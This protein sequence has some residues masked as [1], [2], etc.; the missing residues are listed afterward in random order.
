LADLFSYE[1][2]HNLANG[3]NNS[4]GS[5]DNLST[6]CGVE[7]ETDNAAIIVMRRRLRRNQIACLLLAQGVPMLLAGDEVANSQGGNNN[8][9]AQDNEIGW[10]DWSKAGSE[11]DLSALIGKLTKLRREFAQL[12]PRHWLKGQKADSRYDVKWLT[13]HANE[14]TEADWNLAHARFLSYVL[15]SPREGG[16]PLFIVL[17][18]ADT[19]VEITFPEWRGVSRWHCVL[20]TSDAQE[21]TLTLPP[22]ANWGAHVRCV[23]AF[24]GEP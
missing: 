9:Y 4:D 16:R 19:P 7:G 18:G 10:V 5:N 22:G 6:N 13:P 11:D 12:R 24:A 14:M 23:L 17:N 1:R 3:E 21:H 8:A 20:D 2:K 15:A